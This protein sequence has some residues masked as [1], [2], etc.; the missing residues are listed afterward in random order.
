MPNSSIPSALAARRLRDPGLRA[1]LCL[2]GLFNPV[3]RYT[4]IVLTASKVA[5][6]LAAKN[7]AH[8]AMVEENAN[9]PGAGWISP[10][11]AER[12]VASR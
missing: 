9:A 1:A 6:M 10:Q 7:E 8:V 2:M 11:N 4:F 12:V 5:V 3:L